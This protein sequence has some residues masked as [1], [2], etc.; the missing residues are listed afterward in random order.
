MKSARR[1]RRTSAVE[2]ANVAPHGFW[3]LI[4]ERENS[5]E[6]IQ[7][8]SEFNVRVVNR[9]DFFFRNLSDRI[10]LV[11]VHEFPCNSGGL[12]RD[13]DVLGSEQRPVPD[14]FFGVEHKALSLPAHHGLAD[15]K[16]D[17]LVVA[18]ELVDAKKCAALSNTHPLEFA[19]RA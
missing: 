13:Q 2:V 1:G 18:Q 19:A 8:S 17:V 4:D 14:K 3:L 15:R 10:V 5:F 6:R 9:P 7:K 12:W 16:E 11:F